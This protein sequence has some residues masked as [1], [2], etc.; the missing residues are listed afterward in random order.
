M[1]LKNEN[2]KEVIFEISF[3]YPMKLSIYKYLEL[4]FMPLFRFF[5]YICFLNLIIINIPRGLT[6]NCYNILIS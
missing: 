6:N 2:L 1:W 5:M 3:E 4:S